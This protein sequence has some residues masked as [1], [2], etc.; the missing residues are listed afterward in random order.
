MG[1][2]AGKPVA[3]QPAGAGQSGAA[4]APAGGS[5]STAAAPVA[6]PPP[7]PPPPRTFTIAAGRSISVYTE[8]SLTTKSTKS[9]DVFVGSLANAIV[10]GDWVVAKRGAKVEGVVSNSDPGGKVKGVASISVKLK[11]LQLADGRT[12]AISTTN[13]VREAKSTKKKDAA[14]IGIG[15]GVGAAIGAIA[16]GG[17]GA[18]I[19]AGV[20]GGGGTAM[21]LATRGD[22]AVIPAESQISFQMTS[23]VKVTKQR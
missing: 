21:V 9:G 1:S 19:G 16:G 17:K 20:G 12:V 6:P 23:A 4:S 13:Y 11:S 5:S 14:K 10:D 18:A 15:A 2:A 8:N 22:P 7:P 3:S